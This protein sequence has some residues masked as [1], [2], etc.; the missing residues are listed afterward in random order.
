MNLSKIIQALDYKVTGGSEY[1]WNCFGPDARFLDFESEYAHASIVFDSKNQTVYEATVTD[2]KD[3]SDKGPYRW[4]NPETKSAH[5]DEAKSKGVNVNK[6]WDNIDWIELEI[7]DDFLEKAKAVFENL[8]FDRRVTVPMDLDD[9]V[10]L[11]LALEAH[12]KD[13]TLNKMIEILLQD[14]IDRHNMSMEI[15]A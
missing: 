10:I 4:L 8:P 14:A 5:H 15:T 9:D 1:C 12:K 7:E 13:I 6:A 11:H 2:K 3:D